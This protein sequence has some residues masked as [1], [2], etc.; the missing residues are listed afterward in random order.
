[1]TGMHYGLQATAGV[2][3]IGFG[4]WYAYETG[5][6]NGLLNSLL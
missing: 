5:I 3:S 2:L 4:S 6:A 1:M